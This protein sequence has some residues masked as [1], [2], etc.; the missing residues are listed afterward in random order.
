MYC[1]RRLRTEQTYAQGDFW[2]CSFFDGLLPDLT[3][4]V[5]DARAANLLTELLPRQEVFGVWSV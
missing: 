1:I 4:D 3:D 5:T 2:L